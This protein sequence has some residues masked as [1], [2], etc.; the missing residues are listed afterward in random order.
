LKKIFRFANSFKIVRNNVL[1]F[2]TFFTASFVGV[3]VT[4]ITE[5]YLAGITLAIAV[6]SGFYTFFLYLD[7]LSDLT[8]K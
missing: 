5:K 2:W 7:S 3:T 6:V 1:F 8:E 4:I